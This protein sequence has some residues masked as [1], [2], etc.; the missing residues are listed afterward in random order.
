MPL[1]LRRQPNKVV[2]LVCE[3]ARGWPAR[4][5]A[6]VDEA[7]RG[8]WCGPVVAAAVILS[9]ETPIDALADSKKLSS[10]RRAELYAILQQTAICS[11]GLASAPEIDEVN[12]LQ[13]TFRAMCRALDGLC[14]D[15][16]LIDGNRLPP[17]DMSCEAFVRGDSYIAS[18]AA[19]S[20]VAKHHRDQ[21]MQ[22]LAEQYPHYG[23]TQNKGYGTAAH[24]AALRT[25]GPCSQHRHSFKPVQTLP[26]TSSV[27]KSG[28][29]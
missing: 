7:G 27:D 8:A 26:T 19:A 29:I 2:D 6:G 20:I 17:T 28:E 24:F 1:I 12:I 16:A 23:W 4:A 14:A 21:I 25:H 22:D 11:I 10:K 5:V 15:Y 13:A 9:P 3:R 18:I